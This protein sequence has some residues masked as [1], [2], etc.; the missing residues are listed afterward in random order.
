MHG[1]ASLSYDLL[2]VE[3]LNEAGRGWRGNKVITR[4]NIEGKEKR[5]AWRAKK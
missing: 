3:V 4:E 2:D 1:A 5:S